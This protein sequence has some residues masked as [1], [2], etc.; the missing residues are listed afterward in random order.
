[1]K[2]ILYTSW[3]LNDCN[4]LDY[5][6]N[7]LMFNILLDVFKTLISLSD[8]RYLQDTFFW[9]HPSLTCFDI[10]MLKMRACFPGIKRQQS[11]GDY[12]PE[13]QEKRR[14]REVAF[15]WPSHDR[16]YTNRL[17]SANQLPR[18]CAQAELPKRDRSVQME[19]YENQICSTK[20]VDFCCCYIIWDQAKHLF[21]KAAA[22]PN[23]ISVFYPESLG[24]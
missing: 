6:L 24:Y 14:T 2:I 13:N 12:R 16:L 3:L 7:Y 9:H 21:Y 8:N 10:L 15:A 18:I 11:G 23:D 4:I 1:M 20:Y 19:K 5:F 17:L 22:L